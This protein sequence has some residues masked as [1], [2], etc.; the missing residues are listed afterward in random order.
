MLKIFFFIFLG[1]QFEI[2]EYNLLAFAIVLVFFI[3]ILR[4]PMTNFLF[5]ETSFTD[6]T[7]I[8]MMAP[9]GLAAAVLASIPLTYNVPGS[10]QIIDIVSMVVVFSII[11]CAVLVMMFRFNFVKRLYQKVL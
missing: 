1:I 2:K 9:K 11:L 10:E 4:I 7:Y 3:F 6:K 5:K 8:S